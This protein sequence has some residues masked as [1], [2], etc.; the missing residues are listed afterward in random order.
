[1]R[2]IKILGAVLFTAVIGSGIYA[3]GTNIDAPI[4]VNEAFAKKFPKVKKVKWEK[5]SNSE[6]EGEFKIKGME[7]S[8]NFLEDGTWKETEH[9]I[10]RN[11]I[12]MNIKTTLDTEFSGYKIEEAEIS[13]T[14]E[15]TVYEFELEKGELN[16]EIS[17]DINGKVIS[18][19]SSQE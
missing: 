10:K 6:W 18:K 15:G 19:V 13:E 17:I 14:Q 16:T 8:A 4:K 5:E 12:P 11:A 7:Y 1:M 3:F 2:K 9:E